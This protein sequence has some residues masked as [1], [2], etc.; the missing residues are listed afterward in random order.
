[1]LYSPTFVIFTRSLP[2]GTKQDLNV[3]DFETHAP[4]VIVKRVLIGY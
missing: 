1:M 4:P 2:S 3:S